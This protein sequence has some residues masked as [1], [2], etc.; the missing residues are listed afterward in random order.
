MVWAGA[1]MLICSKSH[2]RN[3]IKIVENYG[4]GQYRGKFEGHGQGQ[5]RG[6]VVGHGQG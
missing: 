4:Q 2:K 5:C 3:Q 6:K 1:M